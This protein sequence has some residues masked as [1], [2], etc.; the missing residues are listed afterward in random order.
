LDARFTTRPRVH[1][2]LRQIADMMRL[3]ISGAWWTQRN[4]QAML[5]LR[6]ARANH[7][8]DASWQTLSN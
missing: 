3:K 2:R 1:R 8:W 4:A 7:W 5:Q 6:V